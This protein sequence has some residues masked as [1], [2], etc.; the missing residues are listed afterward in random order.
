[1]RR[2]TACFGGTSAQLVDIDLRRGKT[3][4]KIGHVVGFVHHSGDMQQRL[5]WNAADV[6]T[7]A[8]ERG[9]TLDD[10]RLHAEIGRAEGGGVA[11][12]AGAE[13]QHFAFQIGAATVAGGDWGR[14]SSNCCGRLGFWRNFRVDRSSAAFNLDQQCA[15]TNLGAELNQHFLDDAFNRARHIHRRLVRFQRANRII[16]LDAV[17][18][19]DEQ[20]D[21]RHFGEIADIGDFDFYQIAHGHSPLQRDAAEIGQ[22]LGDI[23]IETGRQRAVDNAVISG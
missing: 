10:D 14:R 20:V 15:F 17:A 4:A 5:G 11:A 21:D 7:N 12:G 23:D 6:Q 2:D 8:A 22:Q 9:V 1:M 19:L 13:H 16:D 3:D 18:D